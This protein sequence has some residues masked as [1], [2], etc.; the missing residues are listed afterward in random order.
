V[1]GQA[2]LWCRK[3]QASAHVV[4]H[5]ADMQVFRVFLYTYELTAVAFGMMHT[6][7]TSVS[8][9]SSHD[10]TSEEIT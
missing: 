4:K 6:Y 1:Q 5:D 8:Q 3:N 9:K 2:L 10:L 7:I